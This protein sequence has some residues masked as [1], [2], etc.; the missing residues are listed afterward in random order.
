MQFPI[1]GELWPHAYLVWLAIKS[2][3]F[4]GHDFD[5][6][7][8]R[9]VTSRVTVGLA[10]RAFLWV[11]CCDHAPI[12]HHYGYMAPQRYW[13]HNLDLLGSRD[14]IG[15]VTIWLAMCHFLWVVSCD[16]APILH[17]YGH[18]APQTLDI[19][20]NRRTDTQVFLHS[21]HCY[22]LHWTDKQI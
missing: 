21:V 7:S 9:D 22:A 5:L 1:G 8:S 20:T 10:I 16:H 17:H 3:T 19:W 14:I 2:Q 18:M 12:L 15:H 11:V 4:R 6:L 13:G